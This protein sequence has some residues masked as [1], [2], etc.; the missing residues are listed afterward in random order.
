VRRNLVTPLRLGLFALL[1]TAPLVAAAQ[2]APDPVDLQVVDGG[3]GKVRLAVTAGPSGSPAGFTVRWMTL[4]A[5]QSRGMV[6]PSQPAVGDGLASFDGV[7][8]LNTWGEPTRSF[9]LGPGESIDV[10]IGDLAGE[11]GVA[12]TVSGELPGGETY[13]FTAYAN[14]ETGTGP[15][16]LSATVLGTTTVQGQNCTYTIGYWKTH[17]DAWP[18]TSLTLGTV[19]Y[20]AAQLLRILDA[21]VKGNGLVSLAHQLIAAKLNVLDGADPTAAA[22]AMSNADALVGGLLVPPVGSGY[23]APSATSSTTQTHDDYNNGV[24]GP[25]HCGTVRTDASTWG[26]LK[27]L[28]R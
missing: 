1:L 6:W 15:S 4:D 21:P 5:L 22:G 28:Y 25:G 20:G 23:L 14:A 18:V 2:T 12:G 11:S 27:K 10:E 24:I 3:H 17:P 13:A 16:A 7:A 19:T 26:A 9:R 8:T